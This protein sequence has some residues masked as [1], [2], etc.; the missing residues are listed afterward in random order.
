MKTGSSYFVMQHWFRNNETIHA[1]DP[2]LFDDKLAQLHQLNRSGDTHAIIQLL[3]RLLP[4]PD[5]LDLYT[6]D[7]AIAAMRDLGI[8][9]G[10]LKKHGIEPVEVVPELEY[11]LLVLMVKT[12]LPPRDTLLH[13]SIWNPGGSRIR[14]Y[15]GLD[16]E[17][18][19]IESV[20]IALPDL[21]ESIIQLEAMHTMDLERE[22]FELHCLRLREKMESMVRGVVHAKRHVSPSVFANELRFYYDPIKVDYNKSYMGPGAVEMPMFV[23]DHLLWNCDCE[24]VLYTNF[25]EGYLPYN[26]PFIRE[27]YWR[28]KDK[29]SLISRIEKNLRN[30]PTFQNYRAAQAALELFTVLKSFRMPHKR[31][32]EQAYAHSDEHH[33]NSGS[34]GYTVDILQHIIRLQ[35]EKFTSLQAAMA[36]AKVKF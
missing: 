33:R 18:A 12:D 10:I 34:G 28:F 3:Y 26:L 2:L 5:A 1:L 27:I 25:K 31:M 32:A 4:M 15:T 21:M 23:F 16:D 29:P 13:Y 35:A 7:Q 6:Y 22:D 9:I 36:N 20:K 24:D 8:F 17:K 11:V 19:L 30:S 14:T